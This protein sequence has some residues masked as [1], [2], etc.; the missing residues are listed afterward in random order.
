MQ[1]EVTRAEVN[2]PLANAVAATANFNRKPNAKPNGIA[3]AHAKRFWQAFGSALALEALV[4]GA[5]LLWVGLRPTRPVEAAI[6]LTIEAIVPSEPAKP[7]EPALPVPPAKQKPVPPAEPPS[8]KPLPRV[9]PAPAEPPL[10]AATS[11]LRAP[12]PVA[13][14]IAA[15]PSTA[16]TN[17]I[18]PTPAIALIAPGPPTTAPGTVSPP[19]PAAISP[20]MPSAAPAPSAEPSPAYNARLTSAAQAAFEVPG[21]VSSLNFKGRTRVGFKLRDGEVSGVSVMQPSGLGAMDRAA[22]KAVQT[23]HYPPPPAA[24]QSK[25]V[26]Y[27]IWVTHA[28]AN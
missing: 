18:V 8:A 26:S 14:E 1:A 2:N 27:E 11:P 5:F 10:P 4:V 25:E 23:A 13:P 15:P 16:P 6:P 19:T 3:V 28:P 24:L 7:S 9:T 22:V 21:S 20:V 17:P 12:M